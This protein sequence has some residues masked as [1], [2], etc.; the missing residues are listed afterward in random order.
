VSHSIVSR[1]ITVHHDTS[2]SVITIVKAL[3]AG[4][5]KVYDIIAG[6]QLSI[7]SS[8]SSL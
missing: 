1:S 4:G 2:L 8:E 7:V 6:P 3:D 5:F